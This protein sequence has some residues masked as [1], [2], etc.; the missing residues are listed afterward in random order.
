MESAAA[1]LEQAVLERLDASGPGLVRILCGPGQNGGDGLALARRLDGL[2]IEVEVVSC[3]DPE[4]APYKGDAALQAAALQAAN[5]PLLAAPTQALPAIVIDAIL[6]TG[7][8]RPPEGPVVPLIEHALAARN[9]GAWV[10]TADTPS[11]LDADSGQVLDPCVIADETITFGVLKR[12][13]TAPNA[14]SHVGRIRLAPLGLPRSLI[15]AL[16]SH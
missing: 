3:V 1:G 6:G 2:H 15:E 4:S 9:H 16:D 10:I 7:L 5:L 8:S 12:G 14:A 13:L 11:G